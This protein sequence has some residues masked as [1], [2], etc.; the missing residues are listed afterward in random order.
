MTTITL[1][2][3]LYFYKV[4]QSTYLTVKVHIPETKK[5]TCLLLTEMLEVHELGQKY[6][7][8]SQYKYFF[9]TIKARES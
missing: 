1:K 3:I 6:L 9:L 7:K 8:D 4:I 2:L 5:G